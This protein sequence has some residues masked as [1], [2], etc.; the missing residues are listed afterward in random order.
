MIY[1][2]V[3]IIGTQSYAS[4]FVSGLLSFVCQRDKQQ[5]TVQF[6]QDLAIA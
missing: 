1:E 5:A 2:Q 6:V 4:V 3:Q